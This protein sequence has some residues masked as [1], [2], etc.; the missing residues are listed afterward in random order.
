MKDL[1]KIMQHTKEAKVNFDKWRCV[2]FEQIMDR[3]RPRVEEM[4]KQNQLLRIGIS[5]FG[6]YANGREVYWY[7]KGY[8][9]DKYSPYYRISQ[10]SMMAHLE[11][12]AGLLIDEEKK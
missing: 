6:V 7:P 4:R 8:Q 11:V 9:R 2:L 5:D 10:R 12:I 1:K 3:L